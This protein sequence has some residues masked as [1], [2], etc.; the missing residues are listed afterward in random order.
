MLI[1]QRPEI[2]A[3]EPQGNVQRF[4]VRDGLQAGIFFRKSEPQAGMLGVV[5]CQPGFPVVWGF[6]KPDVRGSRYHIEG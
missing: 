5:L 1:I 6:E 4:E 3:D 2:E